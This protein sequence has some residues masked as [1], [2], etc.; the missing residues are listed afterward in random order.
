MAISLTSDGGMTTMGRASPGEEKDMDPIWAPWRIDYI[1]MEKPA[2]CILCD[3]PREDRDEANYILHRAERNF[4]MLNAYPYNPGHLL[5]VPY[6]HVSSAEHLP[7]EDLHEHVELIAR[8]LAV[9]REALA[10]AGFNTGM[11]LGRSAGAGIDDH[12]HSHIVPRWQ[13]DSNFMPVLADTRVIPEA[14]ADTYR[15]L[16]G[17]F[18]P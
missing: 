14:L 4:I 3:K 7:S 6:R 8:G 12:V 10:P 5:I 15:Q 11:N 13:G 16:A 2:G 9:L 17:R 18:A 1:R